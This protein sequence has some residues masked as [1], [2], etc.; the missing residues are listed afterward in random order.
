MSATNQK[1]IFIDTEQYHGSDNSVKLLFPS[2]TLVVPQGFG[3]KLSLQQFTMKKTFYNINEY[4]RTFY[5]YDGVGLVVK[6]TVDDGQNKGLLS[7]FQWKLWMMM[8]LFTL[9]I[10]IYTMLTSE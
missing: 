2:Q 4:N 5:I 8:F 6:E 10:G 9:I 1:N 3:M 7:V